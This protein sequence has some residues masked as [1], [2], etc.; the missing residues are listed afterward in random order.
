MAASTPTPVASSARVIAPDLA[1][2]LMLLFIAIANAPWYL[3]DSP[4]GTSSAHPPGATGWDLVAQTVAIV[5]IDARTYPMFAA[6]FGYG[7]WQLYRRQLEAGADR[8]LA[9]R[10]LRRRHWWMIAFG[11]V[12]AALLWMGDVVA[13]WGLAGLVLTWLFLD[14]RDRTLL[15][16]AAGLVTALAAAGVLVLGVGL[17]LSQFPAETLSSEDAVFDPRFVN[18]EPNYLLSVLYRLGFWFVIVPVQ[19]LIGLVAPTAILLALVAARHR[20][21]ENP[22]EHLPL[23]RRVALIGLPIG[24][25]F[26]AIVAAQNAGLLLPLELD[27]AFS[28]VN[29]LAGLP[30]ALGYVAVFGLLAA[31]L[32]PARPGRAAS[33]LQA[34]GKRSLTCYLAQSVVF[35][36]LLCA[37]G[38]GLGAHL[39]SWSIALVAIGTWLLTVVL[40]VALEARG[41]RGPAEWLLRRLAYPQAGAAAPV[42]AGGGPRS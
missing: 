33:A 4:A 38:F 17:M 5:F 23:L 41:K 30:C 20:V 28:A 36:P 13:A 21:L 6:L 24:W 26:G 8:A 35:A 16:W 42:S 27:W 12:H 3:W 7:I 14:R 10:I 39:S 9:R 32:D 31:R 1:R 40:A 29:T 37:W 25:G 15:W 18:A 2:G 19:G 11:A 22:R 34:V